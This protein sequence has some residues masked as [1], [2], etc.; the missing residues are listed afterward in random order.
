M[1]TSILIVEDEGL[2]AIDLKRKLEQAG[3]ISVEKTFVDRKPT[4]T[5]RITNAGRN[6]LANYVRNL[7]KL[8]GG[9]FDEP[10]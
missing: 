10:G 3:Y 8:L 7:K 5:Y 6:A 9:D 2:I 1:N 4:S